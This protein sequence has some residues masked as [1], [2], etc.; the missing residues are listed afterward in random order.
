MQTHG[1]K[2]Y[3]T[4]ATRN[5]RRNWRGGMGRRLKREGIYV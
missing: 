1:M 3:T 5:S 4:D 2:M